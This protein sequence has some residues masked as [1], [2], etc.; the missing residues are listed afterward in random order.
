MKKHDHAWLVH[1]DGEKTLVHLNLYKFDSYLSSG[2]IVSK[3][4]NIEEPTEVIMEY[5][6]ADNRFKVTIIKNEKDDILKT[7]P[8]AGAGAAAKNSNAQT[9]TQSTFNSAISDPHLLDFNFHGA[10]KWDNKVTKANASRKKKQYLPIG[11]E[12]QWA[13][14]VCVAPY[15]HE[16]EKR[17]SFFSCSYVLE[18]GEEESLG[19]RARGE[20]EIRDLRRVFFESRFYR[21]LWYSMSSRR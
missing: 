6:E 3:N 18:R 1:P 14:C 10:Y 7:I 12:A 20:L 17:N 4:L 8:I 21:I 11:L 16:R 5:V 15:G 13:L 2:I 9:R 19:A